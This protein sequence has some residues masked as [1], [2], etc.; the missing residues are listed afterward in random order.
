MTTAAVK[1]RTT[2]ITNAF[3]V[4]SVGEGIRTAVF[5]MLA[6][7]V[8]HDPVAIS[9]LAVA[10]RLPWLVIALFSGAIADR[11][12]RRLLM[13]MAD[14]FRAVVLISLASF[15]LTGTDYLWLLF[16]SALALGTGDTLFD[17]ATQGLL[18]QIT[19][20][21][22]LGRLNGQIQT[23][24]MVGGTFVGPLFG[25]WL[26]ALGRIVPLFFNAATFIISALFITAHRRQQ[27]IASDDKEATPKS[28]LLNEVTEGLRWVRNHV[29][30]RSLIFTVFVVN[31]TQSAATSMLVLLATE[32]ADLPVSAYGVLLSVSGVGAFIGGIVSTKFGDRMDLARVIL[33]AILS[34]CPIMLAMGIVGNGYVIAA[35]LG[36]D[37][38]IGVIAAVQVS[39]LRQRM[40]PNT[41]LSRVSS[42][43]QMMT[44]GLA[45]PLGALGAG[46]LAQWLDVRAVYIAAGLT[47]ALFCALFGGQLAPTKIRAALKAVEAEAQ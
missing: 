22:N 12:D 29:L 28:S 5:P 15:F 25:G 34:M 26:F 2:L 37:S 43:S 30:V 47:V 45:I 3:G 14:A 8:T 35:A 44:F 38:L 41:L 10:G 17:T 36:L 23:I 7:S 6:V 40:V 4:S 19:D 13:L 21:E 31:L 24:N 16:L 42:V 18:P 20:A 11:Y 1:R 39:V 33:P 32:T 46:F 27:D 9:G